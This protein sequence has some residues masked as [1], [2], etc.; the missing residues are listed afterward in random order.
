MIDNHNPLWDS[1]ALPQ[2]REVSLLLAPLLAQAQTEAF[3]GGVAGLIA[4][5]GW[6]ARTV[7]AGATGKT[8]G[9]VLHI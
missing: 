4:H 2:L 9:F 1:E 8:A 5:S 7:L 6:M 3:S